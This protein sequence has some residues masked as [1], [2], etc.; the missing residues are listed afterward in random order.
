MIDFGKGKIEYDD[1]L[2]Y[3]GTDTILGEFD[4]R[5]DLLQVV[6][7]DT[8][9][10]DLGWYPEGDLIN[11]SF[12]LVVIKQYDWSNPAYTKRFKSLAELPE[13]VREARAATGL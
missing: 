13:H 9:L 2:Q 12:R 6:Y 8:S 11:G 3:L 5:E 1:I 10:L 7:P 4:L